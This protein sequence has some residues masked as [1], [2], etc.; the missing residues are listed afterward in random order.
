MKVS[1]LSKIATC[2]CML[3]AFLLAGCTDQETYTRKNY[4]SIV[5][6]TLAAYITSG[7]DTP[8]PA[9]TPNN[10]DVCSNCNGK[11]K[12]GD[13]TVMFPC[14]V[15][16]GTGKVKGST[17]N[18]STGSTSTSDASTSDQ[19]IY[20]VNPEQDPFDNT[21]AQIENPLK[22]ALAVNEHEDSPVGTA[23]NETDQAVV[24]GN[25]LAETLATGKDSYF[26]VYDGSINEKP[27]GTAFD[28]SLMEDNKW[29]AWKS[30]LASGDLPLYFRMVNSNGTAKVIRLRSV[31]SKSTSGSELHGQKLPGSNWTWPGDLR[32]HL[33]GSN[34]GYTAEQLA[35]MSDSQLRN[36]HDNDHNGHNNYSGLDSIYSVN[37]GSCPGGNCPVPGTVYSPMQNSGCP[38]GNCPVPTTRS[39]RFFRWR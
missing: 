27:P 19:D 14:V 22:E 1:A 31:V 13:G 32:S 10:S 15:C 7:G 30:K 39:G 29:D 9:P 34:H 16:D 8:A 38:G 24:Y 20:S 5:A 3:V 37:S 25:M 33:M 2:M 26:S 23:S 21:V 35:G 18:A 17:S 6:T 11:G 4:N 36:I 28:V 12:V